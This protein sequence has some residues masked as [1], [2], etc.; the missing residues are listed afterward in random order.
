LTTV[1]FLSHLRA[2]G[3]KV[4]AEN[5]NLRYSAACGALTP[6]LRAKLTDRKAEIM[7]FLADV[8]PIS[9]TASRIFAVPRFQT[10]PM[11]FQQERLWFMDQLR[12]DSAA[13][14]SPTLLRMKGSLKTVALE[15]AIGEL[16]RR[17]ESLRTTFILV[18]GRPAQIIRP[19]EPFSLTLINLETHAQKEVLSQQLL[20]LEAWRPFDINHGP[21]LRVVIVRLDE[22]DHLMLL[23]LHHII[24]DAWSMT[25]LFREMAALFEYFTTGSQ[26][27]LPELAIQYADFAHWQRRWLQGEA[28][29]AHLGYWRGQLVG[30]D[31]R[32]YLPAD[33]PRPEIQTYRGASHALV[34]P[35]PLSAQIAALSHREGAT[36]FMTLLAVY[37]LLLHDYSGKHFIPVATAV[38][39]RRR[40][41]TEPLIGFFVNTLVLGTDLSGEPTFLETLRRVR[42]MALGAFTHEDLPFDRL[43][44]DLNPERDLAAS[45]LVQ[46][47]FALQNVPIQALALPDLTLVPLEVR[48]ETAKFD[49]TLFFWEHPSQFSGFIEYSTDLFDAST[50]ERMAAR[51]LKLLESV[52]ANPEKRLSQL[53]AHDAATEMRAGTTGDWSDNAS[54]RVRASNLMPNQLLIW[55]GQERQPE[56]PLYNIAQLV[57]IPQAIHR[58]HFMRAF[59]ALVA[60]SDALRTIFEEIQSVPRQRAVDEVPFRLNYLD[61]SGRVDPDAEAR[62]WA[63]GRSRRLLD[64]EQCCFD[65]ALIKLSDERFAWYFNAHHIIADFECS[66]LLLSRLSELYELSQRGAL[67]SDGARFAMFKDY[68]DRQRDYLGT[69]ERLAAEAYWREKLSNSPEPVSFYGRTQPKRSTQVQRVVYVLNSD[70]SQVLRALADQCDLET[71]PAIAPLLN[72]FASLLLGYLFRISGNQHISLGVLFSTRSRTHEGVIGLFTELLLLHF[73]LKE[74]DSFLSLIHKVSAEAAQALRH[75][76]GAIGSDVNS[77]A[78]SVLLNYNLVP[79]PRFNGAPAILSVLHPGHGHSDLALNV[80]DHGTGEIQLGFDFHADIFDQDTEQQV[81]RNF[82][83]I[84]DAYLDSGDQSVR[85]V[86]L[87]SPEEREQVLVLF[88]LAEPEIFESQT[89]PGWLMRHNRSTPDRVAAV[90]ED[91]SLTYRTLNARVNRLAR[92]LLALAVITDTRVGICLN[93][94]LD[95]IV[96]VLGVMKAGAAYVPLDPTYP[97]DRLAFMFDD[98]HIEVMLS[99]SDLVER[100]PRRNCEIVC[101]DQCPKLDQ[102]SEEDPA[103]TPS[104]G[105]LAYVI[106]TSGSTGRPKGVMVEHKGLGYMMESQTH[107]FAL[108]PESHILQFA[109]LSFDASIFE[110]AMW[111]RVGGT[112]HVATQSV[113]V[114]GP[115]FIALMER[116]AITN[117]TLPPSVLSVLPDSG[118]PA[119]RTIVVAGEACPTDIVERWASGRRLFNAYGPTESTVWATYSECAAAGGRPDIGH[120]ISNCQ[121]YLLDEYFQPQTFGVA[122]E[123]FIGGVGVARGYNGKPAL[124]ALTFVPDPFGELPGCRLYR[125]GDIAYYKREG[126]IVFCGRADH[127]VK[128]RGFRIE[129]GEIEAALSQH[130]NVREAVV[131]AQEDDKGNRRLVAYIVAREKPAPA[132]SDLRVSLRERLAEFMIPAVFVVVDEF[133]HTLN[134]KVDRAKLHKTEPGKTERLADYVA[135]KT[136]MERAIAAIWQEALRVQRVGSNDNFFDLG[137]HSLLLLQVHGQIRKML[138]RELAI[139]DM[140]KYPTVNSLA[141]YLSRHER[142]LSGQEQAEE[143]SKLEPGKSRLQYQLRLRQLERGD[144]GLR[145][146]PSNRAN[147]QTS[148][149]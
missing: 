97:S 92:H 85:R 44:E 114:P 33:R 98:A 72:V 69:P 145:L 27:S 118:L 84:V 43:V 14:N 107:S 67:H 115:E 63:Q 149:K 20:T 137:G 35:T 103:S 26:P 49:L 102:A 56:L 52:V 100:F 136:R 29:R 106:Y 54:A 18:E 140:F 73:R 90:F 125:S 61:F 144:S 123:L 148:L 111:L 88:N 131:L 70:R 37:Q 95:L 126:N 28:F 39:N 7:D 147:V 16:R 79:Q 5:G 38:A 41:E 127:Q 60:S 132:A 9:A 68:V 2:I 104:P 89:I 45:P 94:S 23:T 120:P 86:T 21:L 108:S 91:Q 24:S 62:T 58:F 47:G 65:S 78:Y 77:E 142:P 83:Q 1:Q 96:S 81:I 93:R 110:I 12:P 128:I 135:P 15:Q 122:G 3:I 31:L 99:Q 11:S 30:K 141:E 74:S 59:E 40:P 36:P 19:A 146:S 143:Q 87:L 139:V 105:D 121:V 82:V 13:Y 130:T 34:V 66:G 50:V 113:L 42:E 51:F 53:L 46:V 17:H 109:S 6:S 134:G 119:L 76:Q 57:I 4:W 101:L 64:L 124:T 133:P 80:Y 25:V 129:A 71:E 116:R 32:L 55:M 48:N 8:N 10:I 138:E 75:G 117:V 22:V 112:I